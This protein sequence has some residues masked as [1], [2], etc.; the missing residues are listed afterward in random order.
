MRPYAQLPMDCLFFTY[1]ALLTRRENGQAV[2]WK[3]KAH[4]SL[5]QRCQFSLFA[6]VYIC[7]L[8][9]LLLLRSAAK[10]TLMLLY[11][12][13]LEVIAVLSQVYSGRAFRAF[14]S[15]NNSLNL[16]FSVLCV[17]VF[18]FALPVACHS[19]FY[20]SFSLSLSMHL[21][22]HINKRAYVYRCIDELFM[23]K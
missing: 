5:R 8:L 11:F 7:V 23:F 9:V 1:L 12:F 22:I 14:A 19:G 6:C 10:N 2:L 20:F 18:S 13:F 4:F 15:G 21:H 16:F 3:G 17:S